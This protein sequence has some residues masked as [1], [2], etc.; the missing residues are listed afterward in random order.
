MDQ[1]KDSQILPS[2]FNQSAQFKEFEARCT[3]RV[4]QYL[5]Q[6]SQFQDEQQQKQE[7]LIEQFQLNIE[8]V[9]K[10]QTAEPQQKEYEQKINNLDDQM[11]NGLRPSE[12][13]NE[14]I[15]SN[16]QNS[17]PSQKLEKI[18]TF[19]Q[20]DDEMF[21]DENAGVDK[22]YS[23]FF[24]NSLQVSEDSCYQILQDNQER[25]QDEEKEGQG[26]LLAIGNL[27]DQMKNYELS[28]IQ[29]NTQNSLTNFN[30]NDD[31]LLTSNRDIGNQQGFSS[32]LNNLMQLN[33]NLLFPN[34]QVD[35]ESQKS[36]VRK[37]F[38]N[39]QFFQS[40][41]NIASYHEGDAKK[42]TLTAKELYLKAKEQNRIFLENLQK[43]S[44]RIHF[45]ELLLGENPFKDSKLLENELKEMNQMTNQEQQEEIY[46]QFNQV[47]VKTPELANNDLNNGEKTCINTLI[48]ECGEQGDLFFDLNELDNSI[49]NGNFYEMIQQNINKVKEQTNFP[50]FNATF[51]PLD[52]INLDQ[53]KS[54][55]EQ[56]DD[57]IV[58]LDQNQINSSNQIQQINN[59]SRWNTKNASYSSGNQNQN[60]QQCKEQKSQPEQKK[61]DLNKKKTI[62]QQQNV[63]P[64]QAPS[65]NAASLI[66]K[67]Y[68]KKNR[69][70]SQQVQQNSNYNLNFNLHPQQNRNSSSAFCDKE[71][72]ICKETL[73]Q[74]CSKENEQD[75]IILNQDPRI[76]ILQVKAEQMPLK[77]ISSNIQ[78]NITKES[79]KENSIKQQINQ[80]KNILCS[81]SGVQNQNLSSFNSRKNSNVSSVTSRQG[82]SQMSSQNGVSLINSQNGRQE[83]N[84]TNG[85]SVSKCNNSNTNQSHQQVNLN[86]LT[87]SITHLKQANKQQKQ[88]FE[89]QENQYKNQ[90]KK[91]T[92]NAAYEALQKIKNARSQQPQQG[93]NKEDIQH[94]SQKRKR[95]QSITG[96]YSKNHTTHSSIDQ[97]IES[98][99]NTEA[100]SSSS[101]CHTDQGSE[102]KRIN[103][104]QSV[105]ASQICQSLEDL[106]SAKAKEISSDQYLRSSL[107]QVRNSFN[108]C[109]NSSVAK[110]LNNPRKISIYEDQHLMDAKKQEIEALQNL[111][112][113]YEQEEQKFNS[114]LNEMN[115]NNIVIGDKKF[116]Q[117]I[118]KSRE[119]RKHSTSNVLG[120]PTNVS[121]TSRNNSMSINQQL[122]ATFSNQQ[123]RQSHSTQHND[124]N[125]VH[126]LSGSFTTKNSRNHEKSS[127]QNS[128]S[129]DSRITSNNQSQN[130]SMNSQVQQQPWF[131]K[132][133][134]F[135]VKQQ[136]NQQINNH[137]ISQDAIQNVA[138]SNTA[139]SYIN[140]SQNEIENKS[141]LTSQCEVVSNS[142]NPKEQINGIIK[143]LISDKVYLQAV[144]LF[145]SCYYYSKQGTQPQNN[146]SSIGAS[147][148]QK[149]TPTI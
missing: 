46:S 84:K 6:P 108:D 31:V 64:Q 24:H 25:F 7:N 5:T 116:I 100:T 37:Q 45:D 12:Y 52:T 38:D 47:R 21:Q 73:K 93:A 69:S 40:S 141:H 70:N 88:N 20:K 30:P 13:N 29:Q 36:S 148:E 19:S 92:K 53:E 144:A 18:P 79:S 142:P 11:N 15:Q 4:L 133:A 51:Y 122:E 32:E 63:A 113:S 103:K 9:L 117:Q 111:I 130:Q 44:M 42:E 56:M 140:K 76:E 17:K 82:A 27:N 80:F 138:P 67:Y 62:K 124:F 55:G 75:L 34:S 8:E 126:R 33:L 128:F 114:K 14:K 1:I 2:Q 123:Q 96:D 107:N 78:N 99:L 105:Q 121:F 95:A 136:Q 58:Q 41:G 110:I 147:F 97:K 127:Q 149:D 90:Q 143:D 109:L 48:T 112:N 119:E 131:M 35:S 72:Q 60:N 106:P 68:N 10:Y 49:D 77:S 91:I 104:R 129:I 71:N 86:I 115:A 54:K 65:N 101:Y 139:R 85:V 120:I 26:N 135:Y 57:I 87:K 146:Q 83:K 94:F 66:N 43:Q 3:E 81:K 132:K 89:N 134:P 145:T 102:F 23:Q 74:H 59:S 50:N 118:R 22:K 137:Q 125:Q 61:Q 39:Q 98:K 16:D 28:S